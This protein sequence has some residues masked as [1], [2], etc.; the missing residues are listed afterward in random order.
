MTISTY[1]SLD[2]VYDSVGQ[3]RF[4]D[5][6]CFGQH[7]YFDG[8][9]IRG[10][11]NS[12][13]NRATIDGNGLLSQI[14]ERM[15]TL[16]FFPHQTSSTLRDGVLLE[17]AVKFFDSIGCYEG[18]FAVS[19]VN[20]IWV[21]LRTNPADKVFT[22]LMSIRDYL[23]HGGSAN[24]QMTRNTEGLTQEEIYIRE[25]IGFFLGLTGVTFSMMGGMSVSGNIGTGGNESCSIFVPRSIDALAA[26]AFVFGDKELCS[27][28]FAQQPVGVG[29]NTSGYIRNGRFS[30][31]VAQRR[32]YRV[33]TYSGMSHWLW[34]WANNPGHKSA[35]LDAMR[36]R[37]SMQQIVDRIS[38]RTSNVT[39]VDA[40]VRIIVE[41][42]E[43]IKEYY[44]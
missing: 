38:Q 30:R 35:N 8:N 32:G 7:N 44:E 15:E 18:L 14:S 37:M 5:N 10:H 41:I 39:D 2:N 1:I 20:S 33:E 40:K 28:C 25:K 42:F 27:D 6:G 34:G 24:Y 31:D 36:G 22:G 3:L 4:I 23:Y 19:P 13:S 21:N 43:E 16:E 11:G 12:L 26:Y 9:Y 17:K 29:L